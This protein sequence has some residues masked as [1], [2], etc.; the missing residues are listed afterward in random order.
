M[1]DVMYNDYNGD[2]CDT[3]IIHATTFHDFLDDMEYEDIGELLY[4]LCLYRF[5]GRE[6]DDETINNWD[7]VK[8]KAW[9]VLRR[10]CDYDTSKY[11]E[12]REKNRQIALEREAKKRES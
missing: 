2:Y 5:D 6:P 4:T 11:K 9:K 10:N 12:R 3:A 8:Q 7:K 1:A